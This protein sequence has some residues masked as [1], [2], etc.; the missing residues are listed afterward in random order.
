MKTEKKPTNINNFT[1]ICLPKTST[2]ISC[3]VALLCHLGINVVFLPPCDVHL[4]PN[5]N[6]SEFF[7]I[8][9]T[10]NDGEKQG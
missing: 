2:L 1:L 4:Y 9:Q 8:F 7:V 5:R 3:C 6:T 10:R